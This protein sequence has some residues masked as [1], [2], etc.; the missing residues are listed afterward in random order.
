MVHAGMV[1]QSDTSVPKP[2][3]PYPTNEYKGTNMPMNFTTLF[4]KLKSNSKSIVKYHQNDW[5]ID[6]RTITQLY[7]SVKAREISKVEFVHASSE[8][9]THFFQ[10][11]R[12]NLDR[13][14]PHIFGHSTPR[15]ILSQYA[16]M[17]HPESK[18]LHENIIVQ[19]YDGTALKIIT[20]EQ[21]R[22]L[23]ISAAN[24]S[25]QRVTG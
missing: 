4:K 2:M 15:E 25:R 10:L 20:K 17:F 3:P 19:H 11:F 9:G 22:Q 23:F 8:H 16:D 14:R 6:Q 13:Q 18:C 5:N 1:T 21:A 12:N 7:Q 24:V